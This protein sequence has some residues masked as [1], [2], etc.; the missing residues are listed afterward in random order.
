[1]K[2]MLG[3]IERKVAAAVGGI[4]A[5]IISREL[6]TT[7]ESGGKSTSLL[8]GDVLEAALLCIDGTLPL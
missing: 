3:Q 5:G 8:I 1:M 2:G 6:L 7:L 4:G